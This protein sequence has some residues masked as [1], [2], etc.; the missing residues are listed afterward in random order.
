MSGALYVR[1]TEN[2]EPPYQI[3]SVFIFTVPFTAAGFHYFGLGF[4]K[5]YQVENWLSFVYELPGFAGYYSM[6]GIVP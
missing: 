3:I 1:L 6:S 4:V 5:K 2:Q